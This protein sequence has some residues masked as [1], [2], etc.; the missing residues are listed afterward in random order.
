MLAESGIG[1]IPAVLERMDWQ[2]DNEF[3]GL[4]LGLQPSEYW[5]RQMYATFQW[6]RVGMHLL[7]FLGADHVMYASDFPH[8]DGTWPDSQEIVATHMEHLDVRDRQ[9]VVCGNAARVYGLSL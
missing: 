1:W 4:G 2:Y 8:P 9:K 5:H 7:P 3:R 6:D